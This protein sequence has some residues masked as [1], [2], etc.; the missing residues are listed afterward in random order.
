MPS[1]PWFFLKLLA[2]IFLFIWIRGTLPRLRTDQLMAFAWKFMLPMTLINII[3]AGLWR[4]SRE[5]QVPLAVG[6]RWL[7]CAAILIAAYY[8]FG[9][10]MQPRFAKR[11]YRYA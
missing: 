2:M 3:V 1:W 9:R 10:A 5:W 8:I 7:V 11:T 4:F 6:V